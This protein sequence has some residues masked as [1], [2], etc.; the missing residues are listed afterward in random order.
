MNEQ[1]ILKLLKECEYEQTTDH[2]PSI[3]QA[4]KNPAWVTYSKCHNWKRY[5]PDCLKKNWSDLSDES[6]II[7]WILC[8]ERA[9]AEEMELLSKTEIQEIGKVHKQ[10]VAEIYRGN[11][12]AAEAAASR[13]IAAKIITNK[14]SEKKD[15]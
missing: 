5:V 12:Q 15:A 13:I 4:L 14:I 7:I 2:L 10:L 8:K 9:D 1:L 11:V 6:K 3:M